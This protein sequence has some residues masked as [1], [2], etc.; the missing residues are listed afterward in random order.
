MSSPSDFFSS[1]WSDARISSWKNAFTAT[2]AISLLPNLLLI[3]IPSS[4]LSKKF[5][6]WLNIKHILLCFAAGG[7]LGDIFLHT[8]PHLLVPH[9]HNKVH[10]STN[11]K[12][13]DVSSYEILSDEMN[14]NKLL[15]THV[16]NDHHVNDAH[17]LDNPS[18][19]HNHEEIGIDDHSHDYNQNNNV[20][21]LSI[22]HDNDA[23]HLD[24]SHSHDHNHVGTDVHDHNHGHHHDDHH[25]HGHG[26]D[27]NT[28]QEMKYQSHDHNHDSIDTHEHN[29]LDNH[30][31]HHDHNH[32]H[33]QNNAN[34]IRRNLHD[35]DADYKSADI[36]DSHS[37]NHNHGTVPILMTVIVMM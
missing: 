11:S 37:H 26:H 12:R 2:A 31:D 17:D 20:R 28:A 6:K 27:E 15:H 5:N 25:D 24:T 3:G 32:D 35:H 34:E 16:R 21:R 30:D 19:D 7:L 14:E 22:D 36:T 4:L 18:H 10:S 13:F 9:D 29:H 33:N 23:H 8:L 1:S